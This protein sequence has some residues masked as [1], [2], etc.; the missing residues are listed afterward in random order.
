MLSL[1]VLGT[2]PSVKDDPHTSVIAPVIELDELVPKI[3]PSFEIKAWEQSVQ[4]VEE[5]IEERE[6][7]LR[8]VRVEKVM[9]VEVAF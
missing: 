5:G 3:G 2:T 8:F 4:T 7:V 9:S 1:T 6:V